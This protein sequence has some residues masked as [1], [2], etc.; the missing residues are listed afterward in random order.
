MSKHLTCSSFICISL[1]KE[2]LFKKH[3]KP[4]VSTL[5]EIQH[6]AVPFCSFI[7]VR[8]Q[9]VKGLTCLCTEYLFSCTTKQDNLDWSSAS[10]VYTSIEVVRDVLETVALWFGGTAN[11]GESCISADTTDR[12]WERRT[13]DDGKVQWPH[14][15]AWRSPERG[16][17]AW[18]GT[19]DA[20]LCEE[21]DVK[22]RE[23]LDVTWRERDRRDD[24]SSDRFKSTWFD[25]SHGYDLRDD[26]WYSTW[27]R[28]VIGGAGWGRT[29][30]A[31]AG[32]PSDEF[33]VG[34]RDLERRV[35]AGASHSL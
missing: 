13:R 11:L 33:G 31:P 17:D 32:S 21:L 7:L 9:T 5:E 6:I 35:C 8:M 30:V 1:L 2:R 3:V 15:I 25:A 4:R 24:V 28:S 23:V 34:F 10:N 18:R 22:P 27:C 19:C 26:V 29:R 12:C 16:C 20:D 14:S